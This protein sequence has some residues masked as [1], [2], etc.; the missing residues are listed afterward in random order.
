MAAWL[1]VARLPRL[2][3]RPKGR[4]EWFANRSTM[5]TSVRL[6]V[7]LTA[8]CNKARRTGMNGIKAEACPNFKTAGTF[9][10]PFLSLG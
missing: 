7:N 5:R 8:Y 2:R 4:K 10:L 3:G 6:A 9:L 1:T